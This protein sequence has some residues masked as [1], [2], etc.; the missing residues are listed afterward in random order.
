MV[1]N[2]IPMPGGRVL[3]Q[4]NIATDT[5][6]YFDS[7]T[8]DSS[9][10]WSLSG[11]R[12]TV[13]TNRDFRS[14]DSVDGSAIFE[15]TAGT[16][17]LIVDSINDTT[18]NFAFRLLDLANAVA[19]VPGAAISGTL[20]PAR[21]TDVYQFDASAGQRFYF[22]NTL[23]A[24][25]DTYLRLLDPYGRTLL[26]PT[27][28][29][30]DIDVS[31]LPY[32]GTYTLLVEGR[33]YIG[34]NANYGFTVQPVTDGTQA[35]NLNTQTDGSIA[36]A[37]QRQIYNFNLAADSRLVF[38]SLTNNGSLNW[39]LTGP[40][41]NLVN[42]R[43]FNSSDSGNRGSATLLSLVAGDYTLTVD[44]SGDA[45]G[46]YSFRLLDLATASAIAL[47]TDVVGTLNPANSSNLY[48]F[49][50]TAGDQVLF[51]R[52]AL[53]GG[54][55]YWRLIDPTGQQL[56][57]PEFFN[58]R[59]AITLLMSG[60][61]TVFFEGVVQDGGV[62]NYTFNLT[63]QGNT[64]PAALTGIDMLLGNTINGVISANGEADDYVFTI[65]APTR[66]IFDGLTSNTSFNWQLEGPR[67]LEVSRP[68]YADSADFGATAAIELVV[69]GTYRMRI[70]GAGS[71]TGNYAFRL[72]DLTTASA[73]TP[74]T[75]VSGTANPANSTQL[76][77]FNATA[78]ERYFFDRTAN[79]DGST[80]WRLLDPYGRPVWGPTSLNSDIDVTA[81]SLTGAYTLLVEGR[82]FQGGTAS[83]SFNLQKVSDDTAALTLNT[84]TTGNIAHTGQRDTYNFTLSETKRI[85]VDGQTNSGGFRWSLQ[86]PRGT[87]TT[88]RN[89]QSTDSVDG[90]SIFELVAGDYTMVIDGVSDTT[91]SY[92]F[93]ML[94]LANATAITAGTP[95]SGTLNPATSTQ[96]YKFDATAGERYYFDR[97]ANAG[98]DTYWRLQDPSGNTV[99]GPTSINSDI[100]V[101]TLTQTGTYTLLVEGRYYVGGTAS[102]AF[103]LQKV[104]DD[105]ATLALDALINGSIAHVGQ[106][107]FYTF[108]LN[109]TKRV[110]VDGQTNSGSFRWALSGPRGTVTSDRNFQSTDSVDG[111]SIY[112]LVAGTYTMVIDGLSDT[113]GSYAFRVL[114]LANATTI[115]PGTSISNTLNPAT[116]TQLYKFD[117]QAGDRYYFDRTANAGG[118]T[119]WRLMDPFGRSVWGPTSI[120]SDID[121]TVLPWAGTYT[122]L[123]EGRYYVGGTA[124]YAFAVQPSPISAAVPITGLSG[125]A[126]QPGPDLQVQNLTVTPLGGT[127]Q[128]GGTVTV[129]WEVINNGDQP[130]N[131]P[132]Q[133]RLLVRNLDRN[134]LIRNV[135]VDYAD[136]GVAA[137]DP[138]QPGQRRV[139]QVTVDLPAGNPGAGN[140]RFEVSTDVT[141][142]VVEAGG[143]DAGEGNNLTTLAAT[144]QLVVY[145]DLQ[146]VNLAVDPATSFV[147]GNTVTVSWATRN[148]G[149]A[150]VNVSF[151]DNLIVRN[152]VTGQTLANL[153]I[154]H[155]LLTDGVLAAG[156]ER[157]RQATF[158]WPVGLPG[159]GRFEFVV[160]SDS[161]FAVFENNGNDTAET[162]NSAR[163]T[164]T[165]A[166][167]LSVQNLQV[168]TASPG[169]GDTVT[170]QWTD[171]NGGNA[172]TP[173]GWS[174]RIIVRN[175]DSGELLLNRAVAYD[176]T[177]P[178]NAALAAGAAL[179]RSTSFTLPNGQRGAGQIQV[180]VIADSDTNGQGIL[181]EFDALGNSTESN[182]SAAIT[183]TAVQRNYADLRIS[184]FNAPATGQGGNTIALNWTVLNAGGDATGNAWSDRLV[185]STDAIYGNADD[186]LLATV[187]HTGVLQPGGSYVATFDATL[188]LFLD[189]NFF[190]FVRADAAE[191]VIEPDTRAD[192]TSTPAGISITSPAADLVVEVVTAPATADSGQL[193]DVLWRVRNQG[194]FDVAAGGSGWRDAV[195]L[196]QDGSLDDADILLGTFIRTAG[197]AQG[198]TYT[199]R[200]KVSLPFELTGSY[201]LLG[202]DRQRQY[203]VRAWRRW[204][205]CGCCRRHHY[206]FACPG[207]RHRN[208]GCHGTQCSIGGCAHDRQLDIDQSR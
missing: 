166:S 75:V 95:V 190:L 82:Y 30:S 170:V 133:D 55:P 151:T 22:N 20:N 143:A 63:L 183:F 33:H 29:G 132:W 81:L 188:P 58:D 189:G 1:T 94:D 48:R 43:T 199:A 106:R 28:I 100:D 4:V 177:L 116:A 103:N 54:S 204:E 182:N 69:P 90:N 25:G 38:D 3:Y 138:L 91:G 89:F 83:Y 68:I 148:A 97:T 202:G 195:Y 53:T 32:S 157:N 127:L 184:Q 67:G 108:T 56:F 109:E 196:S 72:L 85:V 112:E 10:R 139:R 16:Y 187:A 18:P 135:L 73:I 201:R 156:A 198:E 17:E 76:Y 87:V 146:I 35:L 41:G 26:G 208:L 122:L 203:G 200:G 207:A 192:N 11:P 118:D 37:G 162:N 12:G 34:G 178:G 99:W 70:T 155:D 5:R 128:S 62:T 130:A 205:Q 134:E 165:S 8:N 23:N 123:V 105:T 40:L 185:V 57:G 180:Q 168:T 111:T 42:D 88:D 13:T 86:G 174:D 160:A 104:S 193:I 39:S 93:Q 19:L 110:V 21:E 59:A 9:L 164:S 136:L 45:T 120:N 153:T 84:Q 77:Q 158:T 6:L 74:G 113:T 96:V 152:L 119:Y 144:S 24:G 171:R 145:P 126:A 79:S 141:N 129:R 125:P 186:R 142:V 44:G 181:P 92:T 175:L 163:L 102:Y 14:S 52:K 80:H 159:S 124:S 194:N 101:T 66:I 150:A 65:A 154:S 137:N 173:V 46:N 197:L 47:N 27:Y 31:A 176:P 114:D 51:D 2:R 50:A 117:A 36:S 206:N 121:S 147:P 172:S 98:G 149:T 64:P 115:T 140:L 15:L 78:G 161:G 61:Y 167:D 179:V 169:A 60:T 131:A 7:L 191:Q 107:D 49:D 71:T